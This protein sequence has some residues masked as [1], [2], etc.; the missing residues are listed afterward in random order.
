MINALDETHCE[1][2]AVDHT[3]PHRVGRTLARAPAHGARGI[4]TGGHRVELVGLQQVLGI[5]VHV[6]RVGND[7]VTDQE[8]LFGR[9]DTGMNIAG[10]E[11][12]HSSQLQAIELA[13]DQQRDQALRRRWHVVDRAERMLEGQRRFPH[14]PMVAQV[15]QRHRAAAPGQIGGEAFSQFTPVKIVQTV[16]RQLFQ[17]CCHAW[18]QKTF[19]RLGLAWLKEGFGKAGH[20]FQF[21]AFGRDAARLAVG[22]RHAVA[23]IGDGVVE[24]ACQRQPAT[25]RLAGIMEG[26][27]PAGNCA[28]H[29]A[30]SHAATKGNRT[31]TCVAISVDRGRCRRSAATLQPAWSLTWTGNQPEA[32]ATDAVHVRIDNG[33]SGRRCDHGLDR[34]AAVAQHAG[35]ALSRQCMRCNR[36]AATAS[37]GIGLH[38]LSKKSGKNDRNGRGQH[39]NGMPSSGLRV[40]TGEPSASAPAGTSRSCCAPAST[41]LPVAPSSCPH[42]RA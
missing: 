42:A 41:P 7:T 23:C 29:R 33:D 31:V 15:V 27:V 6:D 40:D 34:V 26:G 9:F 22:D 11:R 17:R 4:D 37:D 38:L 24:Q 21:G 32:V 12:V 8:G 18:L 20:A 36:H 1:T 3:H 30:G 28:G 5:D 35:G 39:A 10:A 19:T 25:E 13:E 14:R 2:V 16:A